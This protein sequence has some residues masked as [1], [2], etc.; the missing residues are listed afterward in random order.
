MAV[1]EGLELPGLERLRTKL[2]R[3]DWG[4]LLPRHPQFPASALF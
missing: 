1:E 3:M 4:K 2:D